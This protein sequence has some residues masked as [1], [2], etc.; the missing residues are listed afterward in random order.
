MVFQTVN[1][2]VALLEIVGKKCAW[3][4]ASNEHIPSRQFRVDQQW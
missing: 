3:A 1:V 4:R 2:L